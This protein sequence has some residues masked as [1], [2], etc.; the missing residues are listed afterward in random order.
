MRSAGKCVG[1]AG[2][3]RVTQTMIAEVKNFCALK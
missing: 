2:K 1:E 3:A